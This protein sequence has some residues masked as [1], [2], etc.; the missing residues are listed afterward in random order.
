MTVT[1]RERKKGKKISLYLDI[2]REGKRDYEYL[3]MYLFP[4]PDKGRLTNEDREHNERTLAIAEKV[5]TDRYWEYENGSYGIADKSRLKG[6]FVQY[7][8][9]LAEKREDSKGN[10]GNWDS[11]INYLEEYDPEVTFASLNKD[12][13]TGWKDYLEKNAVKRNKKKL[14]Q[15][16]KVSYYSKVVAAIK[17]AHTDGIIQINP[18]TQVQG[19]EVEDPEIQFLTEAEL[20]AMIAIECDNQLLKQAF[21]FSCYTGL[22]WSDVTKLQWNKIQHSPETGYFVRVKQTKTEKEGTI[23]INEKAMQLIGEKP[24]DGREIFEGLKYSSWNNSLL[25]QWVMDAKVTKRI[26]F[27]CSRHTFATMLLT[28]GVD[29]YTVK[30]LLLHKSIKSTQIYAKV[31]DLKRKEAV[32]KLS[33]NKMPIEQTI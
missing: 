25:R 7:M 13:L 29:I 27:H 3:K 4:K 24:A 33:Y 30:E 6:S 26:T 31:I 1:L 10:K 2:Y 22:R 14:K 32:D 16:S 21:L 18:T 11:A 12:W 17:Q 23:H 15:N 5:R 9:I 20:N 28:K 8:K 19:F